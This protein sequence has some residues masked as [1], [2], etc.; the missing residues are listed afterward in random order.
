M[1]LIGKVYFANKTNFEYYWTPIFPR[2]IK[3]KNFV[4]K[5]NCLHYSFCQKENRKKS[6]FPLICFACLCLFTTVEGKNLFRKFSSHKNF[7]DFDL[8]F[9]YT[10]FSLIISFSFSFTENYGP[11]KYQ[12]TVFK[13]K[14]IFALSFFIIFLCLPP[15]FQLIFDSKMIRNECPKWIVTLFCWVFFTGGFIGFFLWL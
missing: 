6:F 13:F 3:R 11:I 14:S 1:G 7:Q 4:E 2:F 8:F 12:G 5:V 10:L 15:R 9:A